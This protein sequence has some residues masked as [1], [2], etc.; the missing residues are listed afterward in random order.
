MSHIFGWL[1]KWHQKREEMFVGTERERARETVLWSSVLFF[2]H[3]QRR[4]QVQSG[5]RRSIDWIHIEQ[6]LIRWSMQIV[7]TICSPEPIN[8]VL[9]LLYHQW[10]TNSRYARCIHI[11]LYASKAMLMLKLNLCC[12][13]CSALTDEGNGVSTEQW[14]GE[15][16]L[17]LVYCAERAFAADRAVWKAEGT[18]LVNTCFGCI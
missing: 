9:S 18:S 14:D 7:Y 8:I 3:A 17:V 4:V 5:R 16:V 2:T 1:R 6:M 11:Y 15:W 12:R 13:L 10:T